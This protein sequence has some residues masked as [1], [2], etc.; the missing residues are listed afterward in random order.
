[1]N[2]V[3]SPV[4]LLLSEKFC[5]RG[6]LP[7]IALRFIEDHPGDSQSVYLQS[8]LSYSMHTE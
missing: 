3:A 4:S 1:M 5:F 8:L 6:G 2:S 7:K